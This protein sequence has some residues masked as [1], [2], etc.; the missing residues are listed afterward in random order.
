MA[1]K[2]FILHTNH[3]ALKYLNSQSNVNK[4]H[5]KWV[6]FLQQFTFLLKHQ[7]RILNKVVDGLCRRTNILVEMQ[8]KVAGFEVFK[9]NYQDDPHFGDLYQQ[10]Q[11]G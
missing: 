4:R 7:S 6:S 11:Q 2:E 5:A 8:A 10:L 9:E 3:E 1:Y